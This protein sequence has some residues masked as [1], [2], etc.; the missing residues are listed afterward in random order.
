MYEQK[1]RP[2]EEIFLKGWLRDVAANSNI[3]KLLEFSDTSRARKL[4]FGLQV[5]A[6]ADHPEPLTGEH[7]S[8]RVRTTV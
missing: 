1:R 6:G 7:R 3:S 5:R 8:K 2:R 4:I